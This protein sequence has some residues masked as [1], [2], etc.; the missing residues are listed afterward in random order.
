MS[1]I[2]LNAPHHE[3]GGHLPDVLVATRASLETL[4]RKLVRESE[5]CQNVHFLNGTVTGIVPS[6]TSPNRLEGVQV[7]LDGQKES[8]LMA[9]ELFLGGSLPLKLVGATP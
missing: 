2:P 4:L 7:R 9:G 8:Q 6:S 1:G 5:A 3:Y